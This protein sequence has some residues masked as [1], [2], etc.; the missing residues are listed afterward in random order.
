MATQDHNRSSAQAAAQQSFS[1][2]DVEAVEAR[3]LDVLHSL[4]AIRTLAQEAASARSPDA[5]GNYT[6]AIAEMARANIKGI[7]TCIERLTGGGHGYAGI[8]FDAA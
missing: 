7:D 8:E 1:G 6:T 4:T 5:I 3:L 2:V